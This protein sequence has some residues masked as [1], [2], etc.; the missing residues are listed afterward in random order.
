MLLSKLL[1]LRLKL[2]LHDHYLRG[3]L[4]SFLA[5]RLNVLMWLI[6]ISVI[7]SRKG[8]QRMRAHDVL[9]MVCLRQPKN[10]RLFPST[11]KSAKLI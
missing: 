9:R 3:N 2:L 7:A 5:S 4:R 8:V 6:H 11:G 1:L 10:N